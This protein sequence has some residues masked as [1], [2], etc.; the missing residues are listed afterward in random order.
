MGRQALVYIIQRV[1]KADN[2]CHWTPLQ[3]YLKVVLNW[4]MTFT[5]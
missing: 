2:F 4:N 1:E 5:V 3:I